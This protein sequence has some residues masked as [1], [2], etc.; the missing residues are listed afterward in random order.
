MP[1][2]INELLNKISNLK[3][4]SNEEAFVPASIDLAADQEAAAIE[5]AQKTKEQIQTEEFE[6]KVESIPT[7]PTTPVKDNTLADLRANIEA[8][9]TKLNAPKK[10][11]SIG[12]ALPDI[13]AAAHNI[14]NYGQGSQQKMLDT[15]YLKGTEAKKAASKKEDLSQLQNLQKMY[16]DYINDFE[17]KFEKKVQFSSDDIYQ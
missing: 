1:V 3:T 7:V 4:N 12:E 11:V 5:E 16:Q 8:Y 9:R 15:N 17:Y 6:K 10:E 2:D 14:Y 13:L